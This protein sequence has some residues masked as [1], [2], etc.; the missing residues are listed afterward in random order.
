MA[1]TGTG[2]LSA[3][4]LSAR[5]NSAAPPEL[6][7]V[8]TPGEFETAH[9]TGAR[10]IPLDILREHTS[11]IV[12]SL[13]AEVVVVCR[14][15]HRAAQAAELL[16]EAG[17]VHGSVLDGGILGWESHGFGVERGRQRWEIERQ[18]RLVAGSVVLAAVLGSVAIPTLKW[19]AAGIGAGLTYAAVS[20]TCAMGTALAKLPY[21]D[22]AQHLGIIARLNYF[23]GH[24]G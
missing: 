11:E 24:G 3:H 18:V 7:D 23:R 16:T 4:E 21:N 14:S 1:V 8:R 15:G 2:T 17:V 19:V 22:P 10:N 9:I 5:L 6:V 12:G 13:P 20:D